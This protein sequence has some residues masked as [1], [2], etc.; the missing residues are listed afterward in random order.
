MTFA[1]SVF[2]P[3]PSKQPSLLYSLGNV[4]VDG[5]PRLYSPVTANPSGINTSYEP[6][7]KLNVTLYG[8]GS[9]SGV[10]SAR[11]DTTLSKDFFFFKSSRVKDE[12]ALIKLSI[13]SISDASK[14][15]VLFCTIIRFGGFSFLRESYAESSFT[16][17]SSLPKELDDIVYS[18]QILETPSHSAM[19]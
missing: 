5:S 12:A 4:S 7:F 11:N 9:R 2:P 6:A 10:T 17:S 1:L 19:D 13:S 15:K 8:I 3:H 16:I 18:S 14:S